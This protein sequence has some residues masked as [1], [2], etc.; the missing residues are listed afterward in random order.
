MG[1]YFWRVSEVAITVTAMTEQLSTPD[2]IYYALSA[3]RGWDA[4]LS[5]HRFHSPTDAWRVGRFVSSILLAADDDREPLAVSGRADDNG[6]GNLVVVYPEFIVIADASNLDVNSGDFTVAVQPLSAATD[7]QIAT[8]HNF[9]DGVENRPRHKSLEVSF[10]L[11]GERVT[12][13]PTQTGAYG[14]D[15]LVGNTAIHNAYIA[16]RA[17]VTSR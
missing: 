16:V 4:V 9:Y 12:L 3:L 2:R 11:N 6:T 14:E 8:Q 15:T 10:K 5:L 7:L 1:A 17:A 13:T